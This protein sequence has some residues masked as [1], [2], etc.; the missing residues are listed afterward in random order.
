M[1]YLKIILLVVGLVGLAVFGLAIQ[2]IFKKSH[3][4]PDM[5]IGQNQHM[6]RLGVGCATGFDKEE[7]Q[8][9]RK[10]IAYDSLKLS[11]DRN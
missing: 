7:Q 9:A 3:K 4:F 5:H 6:K 8:K 10:K 1:E 11:D 2:V